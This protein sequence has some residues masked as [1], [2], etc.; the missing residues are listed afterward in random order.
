MIGILSIVILLAVITEPGV[1]YSS[2]SGKLTETR[3]QTRRHRPRPAPAEVLMSDP[4][5]R[6]QNRP[7]AGRCTT[8][9]TLPTTRN[10]ADAP[11]A[12]PFFLSAQ[13]LPSDVD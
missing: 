4:A 11:M 6:R 10:G 13:T 3:L 8:D 1:A 2:G 9:R 12:R 5:A 7:D